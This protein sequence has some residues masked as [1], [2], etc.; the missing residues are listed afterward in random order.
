MSS[1]ALLDTSFLITLVNDHRPNHET[2]KQYFRHMLQTEV[3]MYL[4]AIAAAEFAV[5]QPVTDLPLGAFRILNFNLTHGQQAA[6]LM[7]ALVTHDAGDARAAVHDDVKLMAQASHEQIGVILTEDA[8]TLHKYCERL[9]DGGHLQTRAITLKEG[10]DADV[11]NEDGQLG[12]GFTEP[13]DEQP[14]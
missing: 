3:P 9:R 14:T 13:T 4:S 6:K 5:K 12:L 7:N 8:S 11:F 2:A 1:S 10:F